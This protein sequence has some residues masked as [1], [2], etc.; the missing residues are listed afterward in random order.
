[1]CTNIYV[2]LCQIHV[3]IN[4]KLLYHLIFNITDDQLRYKNPQELEIWA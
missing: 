3:T 2:K 4:F 1:M